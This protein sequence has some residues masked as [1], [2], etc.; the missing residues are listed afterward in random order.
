MSIMNRC[1]KYLHIS[2]QKRFK[3]C[4]KGEA[5]SK[6]REK[7]KEIRRLTVSSLMENKVKKENEQEINEILRE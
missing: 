5:W 1:K 3:L 6:E 4:N 2:L 7:I